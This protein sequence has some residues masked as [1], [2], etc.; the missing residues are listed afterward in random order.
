MLSVC[1]IFSLLGFTDLHGLARTVEV[2]G[3]VDDRGEDGKS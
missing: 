1:G 2:G 3:L